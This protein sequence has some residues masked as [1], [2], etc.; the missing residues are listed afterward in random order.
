MG[1]AGVSATSAQ[2]VVVNAFTNSSSGGAGVSTGVLLTVGQIFTVDVNPNDLWN[3]GALPRWS[4]ADGLKVKL[5][6]TGADESLQPLGTLI[7]DIFPLWTQD[8][9]TTAYGTLVGKIGAGNF[10]AIGTHFSGPANATGELK[11]YYWD[12]NN[13]DN[14]QF[15]TA[16]ISAVP[17]PSTWAMM[18]LGFAGIGFLAYRRR[19]QAVALRKA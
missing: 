3:A 9:L 4:N 14:T 8:G 16:T 11:F 15:V 19:N 10:F 5:F 13:W 7:G 18:I 17:E 2:A 6:A 1:L 12:S